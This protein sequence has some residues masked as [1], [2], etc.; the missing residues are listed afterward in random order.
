MNVKPAGIKPW[1]FRLECEFGER[2]HA[3][4]RATVT[5]ITWVSKIDGAVLQSAHPRRSWRP[6]SPYCK[7]S[8]SPDHDEKTFI[9][10]VTFFPGSQDS[11]KERSGQNAKG[12]GLVHGLSNLIQPS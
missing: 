6:R 9:S 11:N 12:D 2:C 10:G 3:G 8:N 1:M 7:T 4:G 5:L